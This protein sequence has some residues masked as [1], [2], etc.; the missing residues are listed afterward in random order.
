MLLHTR[1]FMALYVKAPRHHDIGLSL[2]AFPFL[3]LKGEFCVCTAAAQ[4]IASPGNVRALRAN[5]ENA[6]TAFSS[7]RVKGVG[8]KVP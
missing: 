3:L 6:N 5:I 8:S 1:T 2:F 4:E 7:I